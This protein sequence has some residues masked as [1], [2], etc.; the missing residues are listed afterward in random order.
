MSVTD[1]LCQYCEK[2]KPAKKFDGKEN[3]STNRAW[4]NQCWDSFMAYMRGELLVDEN[5]KVIEGHWRP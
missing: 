2:K 5:G 4:C 3:K 1:K